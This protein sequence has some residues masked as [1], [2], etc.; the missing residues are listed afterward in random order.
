MKQLKLE[1]L[2]D[3]TY[4]EYWDSVTR[5]GDEDEGLSFDE[6]KEMQLKE[7]QKTKRL[8]DVV[9]QEFFI[10]FMDVPAAKYL[11]VEVIHEID[12]RVIPWPG[13]HKNVMVYWELGNGKLVGWNENP[14][15][16]WSFP[17]FYNYKKKRVLK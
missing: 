7:T 5:Y 9:P 11:E 3:L 17:V 16:G 13:I 6:F 2:E 1:D 4:D 10:E 14:A 12:A 15:R 8:K